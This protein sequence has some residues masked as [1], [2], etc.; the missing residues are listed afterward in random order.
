MAIF[1]EV[2]ENEALIERYTLCQ[3]RYC[4]HYCPTYLANVEK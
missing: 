3:K 4:N 2:S 1:S